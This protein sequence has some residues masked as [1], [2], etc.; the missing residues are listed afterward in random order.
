M[1]IT[2]SGYVHLAD[3][4]SGECSYCNLL[5]EDKIDEV[6]VDAQE[7]KYC[8]SCWGIKTREWREEATK[9]V[10]KWLEKQKFTRFEM[11]DI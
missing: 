1:T 5:F 9:E 10:D 11:M 6:Y 7:N 4:D 8:Q 3:K 2:V